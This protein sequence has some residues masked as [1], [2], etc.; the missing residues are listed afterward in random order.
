MQDWLKDI[1]FHWI[2]YEFQVEIRCYA[3]DV[4]RSG[5]YLVL[6]MTVTINN[7]ETDWI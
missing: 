1:G 6:P 2:L 5:D 7:D 4:M 3:Q